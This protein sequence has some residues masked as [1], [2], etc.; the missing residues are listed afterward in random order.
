MLHHK[1]L[2]NQIFIVERDE[3]EIRFKS[4]GTLRSAGLSPFAQAWAADMPKSTPTPPSGPGLENPFGWRP[5]ERTYDLP[6]DLYT[7]G[8]GESTREIEAYYKTRQPLSTHEIYQLQEQLY[9]Q[10]L[11][12][13]QQ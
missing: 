10:K 13:S 1:G 3:D 5:S 8:A 6:K 2:N 4:I 9:W 7:R 12:E 11:Y